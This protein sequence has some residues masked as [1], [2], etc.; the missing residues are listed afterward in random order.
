MTIALAL[1]AVA[2]VHADSLTV[3]GISRQLAAYRFERVAHVRYGLT[4]DVTHRDTAFGHV[5]IHFTRRAPGDA[6]VDFRGYAMSAPVV[7]GH[8]TSL[9]GDGAHLRIPDDLLKNGE[10]II[11]ADFR[12]PIAPAGASII[13]YHDATDG[14]DYLYTLL[15]PSDA[16]L[17]FPCFDQPDLKA[18]VTLTLTTPRGWK[19]L[20]NGALVRADSA[21][22]TTTHHFRESDPISTYLI[23]F[24]AGPW[25]TTSAVIDG[26]PISMWVRASRAKEAQADTLIATNARA[27]AWLEAYTDRKFPFQKFDFLLAPAFPFGGMEHPGAVFYNEESF[28]YRE[29]PTRNQLLGREATIY[30]EVSHQW[31]GDLVTMK[32]FDDLW[33]KEGFATYIAAVMQDDLS[34]G[35]NAWRTFFLRNKP[36]AYGTDASRGTTPVWQSLA[37][38]DQAKSNYGA[39]VY[40]KAP[41]I[42]KQL[43][44]LVGDT[45]F[46]RGLRAYLRD[47]AYANATWQD[48]LG[49]IASVLPRPRQG[50]S[51]LPQPRQGASVLPQPRQGASVIPQRAAL[52]GPAVPPVDTGTGAI[53]LM[54]WGRDYILR[55]GMPVITQR[56]VPLG[57]S[58][59]LE[60][61]QSPAQPLSGPAPWPIRTQLLIVDSSGA[62]RIVPDFLTK[63]TEVRTFTGRAPA[64]VFANA[65]D[66]SYA[67]T[68]LDSA[69]T[70]WAEQHV[71][72][73]K[74]PLQKA[75]T[76]NALWD[77]VRDARLARGRF[78]RVA[79]RELPMERDD[80]LAPFIVGRLA[81]AAD[82]YACGA[83]KSELL[84]ETERVLA[85]NAA[86]SSRSYSVRKSQLDALIGIAKSPSV[87]AHLD[88]ALDST[89]VFGLPLRAPTRWAI[90]THLA[91]VNAP[92][93]RARLVAETRRDSTSEGRRRAFVAGAA[94][95]DSAVKANYWHRWFADSTL[96]EDWVTASLGA[97]NDPDQEALTRR[98]LIPA[99]DTLP[100]IQRNRRI[101]FLGSWLGSFIG[102]QR[103][104]DA[105]AYVEDFLDVHEDWPHDLR[106]KILQSE[107]ELER[108]V[109]IRRACGA[110]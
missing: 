11:A 1:L 29:P 53:D 108:T 110:T 22:R 14:A 49:S 55:P 10:N 46:K 63:A 36:V 12:T 9:R 58:W 61:T 8:P 51:V 3:P 48:L 93:A 50:A 65:G 34:P 26:R 23:A 56:V 30:H 71:G 100:W 42:L 35:A 31:F 73:M 95:P 74:D 78:A 5:V 24:A 91:S 27:I 15:V 67:I 109:K 66:E 47:H 105:L 4:L 16:N 45:T 64:F 85:D 21:P 54:A 25:A 92:T 89:S 94:W 57:N 6:I 62:Q 80:Q 59:R 2:A 43:N 102:G 17:L 86:D 33:L 68:Y 28:I 107:D 99:L 88:A 41:G 69:S 75:M 19:A 72:A 70:R 76:W 106:E 77:L 32:W 97:F 82:T 96:N 38:L 44:Y 18:K 81:R 39:I 84:P 87:L 101:F 90:V 104:A 7:N 40:N 13:S 60:L 20:A 52:S 103:S 37:N 98:Y 79:L 83:A